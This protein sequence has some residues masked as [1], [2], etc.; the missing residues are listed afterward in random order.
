MSE[1]I[2]IA[3]VGMI[4]FKK[5]GQSESYDLMGAQAVRNALKDAGLEYSKI[6]SAYAGYV[7]GDSCAGQAAL[8]H[9]GITGIPIV[10]V[11]NNCASGST[12][13]SLAS[14]AIKHGIHEC[15]LAV[16]FEQMQPGAVDMVFPDRPGPID[17]HTKAAADLV[18][19]SEQ[20][21]Q[22]PPAVQLFGCQV[23]LTK[24]AYGI[25]DTV[26]AEI[27]K[28]ARRHGQHNPYAI[29]REPL[30]TEQI[31]ADDPIFRGLRKLYACPPSCGAAAVIVCTESFAK[32]H[33]L[34]YSVQVIGQGSCTDKAEHFE[35]DPLDIMFRALSRDAASQAYEQ[36]GL[37]PEDIDVI[38]LHDC[39]TSNEILTY[40]A[41]GLCEDGDM[42]KFIFEGQNSYGGQVVICPS[43]GLLAKGHP[44]GA[45]GLSQITELVWHLRGAAGDR[46]V[47][48]AR[49][50]LQ[51]NG[52]L[53][54]AGFVNIIQKVS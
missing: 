35:G 32:R 49:T 13:F 34:D 40:S 31:L 30:S 50:A 44:L 36:A 15:A 19:L 51:H 9:V 7:Y 46:Q 17:R 48:G 27:T 21:R 25:D 43:G 37:G 4:P 29:F 10:N 12:A 24:Q 52:G 53:G 11:N 6:E 22:L 14:Q 45:T 8:Y 5:P 28:K 2:V 18:G 47:E 33:G 3:G 41:L 20:E 38:E 16:G 39:F 42:E 26:L 1:N 54:S 23:D